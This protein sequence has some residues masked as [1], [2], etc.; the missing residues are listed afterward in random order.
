MDIIP[1]DK[2]QFFVG[3]NPRT[4]AKVDVCFLWKKNH[5]YIKLEI[6]KSVNLHNNLVCQSILVHKKSPA[7]N[8]FS[9]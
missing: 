7:L 4:L 6:T 2:L 1:D 3:F 5:H 9:S 8:T